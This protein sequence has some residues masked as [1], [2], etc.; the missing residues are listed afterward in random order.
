MTAFEVKYRPII[1]YAD[2]FADLAAIPADLT[3]TKHAFILDRGDEYVLEP[4][5]TVWQ[6]MTTA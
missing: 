6:K 3:L 1:V 5:S 2:T 4:K